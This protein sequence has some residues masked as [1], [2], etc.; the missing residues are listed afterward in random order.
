MI[1][2]FMMNRQIKLKV[3]FVSFIMLLIPTILVQPMQKTNSLM[4]TLS[5]YEV[6]MHNFIEFGSDGYNVMMGLHNF[7]ASGLRATFPG[8]YLNYFDM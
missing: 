4:S 1:T 3:Y 2:D 6:P 7:V 8:K 5:K